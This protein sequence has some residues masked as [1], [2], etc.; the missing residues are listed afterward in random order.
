MEMTKQIIQLLEILKVEKSKITN[1]SKH[2][3]TTLNKY[4][5]NSNVRISHFLAHLMHESGRLNY[6]EEIASG[7]KY[8]GRKDLGNIVPGYGTKYKGRGLIQITGY[9]NYLEYFKDT[10]IDVVNKPEILKEP[11]QAALSAGWFWDKRKL[12]IHADNHNILFSTLRING[13]FNGLEDRIKNLDI[14]YKYFNIPIDI[15]SMTNSFRN[16]ILKDITK[17]LQKAT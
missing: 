14:C 6:V 4:N 2:I 15:L 10:G 1:F 12:N 9:V 17:L 8:E 5:I 3:E 13:G 7:I 11:E 16:L